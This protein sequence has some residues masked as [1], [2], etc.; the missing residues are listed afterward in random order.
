MC[1]NLKQTILNAQPLPQSSTQLHPT[2]LEESKIDSFSNLK[3]VSEDNKE[4]REEQYVYN[5]EEKKIQKKM[6][7]LVMADSLHS[8]QV[9]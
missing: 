9:S 6:K 1:A 4:G 5:I 8:P 7:N 3:L 2:I